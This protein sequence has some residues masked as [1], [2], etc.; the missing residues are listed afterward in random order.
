V[1]LADRLVLAGIRR[2]VGGRLR[3][4]I[5][6]GAPLSPEVADQLAAVGIRVMEGYG[7]SE[8]TCVSNCNLPGWGRSRFGTVG[9]ALPGVSVRV[10]DDGEVQI[11][12]PTVFAGYHGNPDATRRVKTDDGWLRTGDLG[13][14]DG[15]GFLRIT[16]R[17]KDLIVTSG[18]ENVAPLRIEQRL[19]ADPLVSQALV[20]GDRRPYLVALLAVDGSERRRRALSD[21]EAAVEVGRIVERVNGELGAAERIH[22]HAVL[23]REFSAEA[24]EV[25]PTLKLRRAV[26]IEHCGDLIAQLYGRAEG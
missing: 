16:G 15:D 2:R 18:G 24:G 5:S 12:G 25:T 13:A 11:G 23:P 10:A 8:A 7:L 21:A 6:G 1:A 14:L 9:R 3:L 26:C 4:P 20:L 17:K 19:L 22:R